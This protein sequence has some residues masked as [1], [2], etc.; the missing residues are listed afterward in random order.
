[1]YQGVFEDVYTHQS[2]LQQTSPKN[3]LS[4]KKPMDQSTQTQYLGEVEQMLQE[5]S[6]SNS[7]SRVPSINTG[8]TFGQQEIKQVSKVTR[9]NVYSVTGGDRYCLSCKYRMEYYE[10]GLTHAGCEPCDSCHK[11][12]P[13]RI[14][15]RIPYNL[16]CD[17]PSTRAKRIK[18]IESN[19]PPGAVLD[20]TTFI[21]PDP[22]DYYKIPWTCECINDLVHGPIAFISDKRNK[23]ILRL[24]I[25]DA[26]F[27]RELPLWEA[28]DFFS[29]LVKV[30]AHELLT[31]VKQIYDESK[32][33]ALNKN[34]TKGLAQARF[35]NEKFPEFIYEECTLS[36]VAQ[37]NLNQLP[38]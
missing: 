18:D 38:K 37:A 21:E 35:V 17:W 31:I 9:T 15:I 23:E 11:N 30:K 32:P 1:M 25:R 22:S 19:L 3:T 4:V 7:A 33:S 14:F 16:K 20:L 13:Q 12:P 36:T 24:T 34:L 27:N 26:Y 29:S 10:L 2:R 8:K 28:T 6:M 5:L